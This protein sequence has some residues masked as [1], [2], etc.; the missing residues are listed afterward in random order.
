MT[1]VT[2]KA[3]K[4]ALEGVPDDTV[5]FLGDDEELNGVHAAYYMQT[6]DLSDIPVGVEG[7]MKRMLKDQC[8]EE[9]SNQVVFLI[10]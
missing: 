9:L 8:R 3:L 4:A 5:V 7:E 10:S 2:V 6:E 1:Q